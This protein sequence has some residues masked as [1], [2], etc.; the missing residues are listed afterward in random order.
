MTAP[1]NA[2]PLSPVN[3]GSALY[4]AVTIKFKYQASSPGDAM[5]SYQLWRH[6]VSPTTGGNEYWN[7]STWSGTPGYVSLAAADQSEVS[8]A[9]GAWDQNAAY[10]WS[11]QVRNGAA[12]AS[13]FSD[14][15]MLYAHAA[16][17]VNTNITSPVVDSR[18]RFTWIYTGGTG[19]TQAGYQFA[20][21]TDA[22]ASK[23]GFNPDPAYGFESLW[24]SGF[25]FSG[26]ANSERVEADL[27][28]SGTY[29]LY[30]TVR[31]D[32]GLESGWVLL[33]T[34]TTS[35]T[36][37][38]SPLVTATVFQEDGYVEVKAQSTY[39]L[40]TADTSSFEAGLGTW[41]NNN[42]CYLEYDAANKRM[43]VNFSGMTYAQLDALYASF[44]L[45][46][47]GHA[48]FAAM[49]THR[50]GLTFA[51]LA[52]AQGVSGVPVVAATVYSA[53]ASILPED[54]QIQVVMNIN[55]Y[56]SNGTFI[57]ST[58]GGTITCPLGVETNVFIDSATAPALSAYASLVLIVNDPYSPV[59][60]QMYVDRVAMAATATTTWTP[61]GQNDGLG[62]VVQRS[63]EGEDWEYVWGASHDDPAGVVGQGV[64]RITLNDRAVP[65]GVSDLKYRVFAVTKATTAPIYS[66]PTEVTVTGG[67]MAPKWFL[68]CVDDP[69]CDL[70]V[71]MDD[72]GWSDEA[73]SEIIFPVGGAVPIAF[74]KSLPR[75]AVAKA[76]LILLSQSD[77][78]KFQ[79]LM[80]RNETIF[81]QQN[82]GRG[83]YLRPV[84]RVSYGMRRSAGANGLPSDVHT[85]SFTA[86]VMV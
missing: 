38:P 81:L 27:P 54:R 14:Y 63:V 34:F 33:E 17:S 23:P 18:P 67:V 39:N 9:C 3:R 64:D 72:W 59:G 50:G 61:G 7:G 84:G 65:L 24:D 76:N 32:T 51:S 82:I 29:K 68:R 36:P 12:E 10:E 74:T 79:S 70:R 85:A 13:G 5:A 53:V 44:S 80:A 75:D 46:D 42:N 26:V 62:F 30:G 73:L 1:F 56:Q 16:P 57:S 55:W 22:E 25:K 60:E 37:P 77:R 19:R 20:V 83:F 45:E 11:V 78:L 40:L 47:A 41:G 28:S 8:I 58:V 15:F 49:S 21:Y 43:K 48:S 35:F 86:Q 2:L 31:D 4:T 69:S 66:L 6:R 71:V 52:T